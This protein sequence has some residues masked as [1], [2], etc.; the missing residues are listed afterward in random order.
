MT[1]TLFLVI[2]HPFLYTGVNFGD[3]ITLKKVE[4]EQKR[5]KTAE[6]VS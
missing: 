6:K 2:F 4:N 5:L 1:I 3:N